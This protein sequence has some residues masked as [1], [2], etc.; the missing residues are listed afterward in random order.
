[1]A[2]K[3][4]S[5]PIYLKIVGEPAI[6][7]NKSAGTVRAIIGAMIFNTHADRLAWEQGERVGV[8]RVS[9]DVTLQTIPT[10]AVTPGMTVLDWWLTLAYNCLKADEAKAAYPELVGLKDC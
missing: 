5:K 1:M 3:D 2:L 9:Y 10:V 7:G 4:E 6:F 8:D